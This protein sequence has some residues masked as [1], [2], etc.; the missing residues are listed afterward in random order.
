[1]SP[2]PKKMPALSSAPAAKRMRRYRTR[3]RHGMRYV[4]VQMHVT[5]ID[6]LVRKKY[7][8]QQ[9]RYDPRAL[10]YAIRTLVMEAM[11]NKA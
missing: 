3:R 4:R 2:E 6:V 7:L 11:R 1:M 10:E 8:D 5:E 9:S